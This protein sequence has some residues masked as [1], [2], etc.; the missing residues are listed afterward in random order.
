MPKATTA[1][2]SNLNKYSLPLYCISDPKYLCT[3]LG[4]GE[5]LV[6]GEGGA[7]KRQGRR[8]EKGGGAEEQVKGKEGSAY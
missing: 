1:T 3:S 7:G 8:A 5:E 6:Q 2:L 4:E